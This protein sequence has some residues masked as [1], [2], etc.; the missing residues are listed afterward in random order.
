MGQ[1]CVVGS[2]ETEI[3]ISFEDKLDLAGVAGGESGVDIAGAGE[4]PNEE[5]GER[6]LDDTWRYI[7]VRP[8]VYFM[9]MLTLDSTSSQPI[10]PTP[11]CALRS[12]AWNMTRQ[13]RK[14]WRAWLMMCTRRR[15]WGRSRAQGFRRAPPRGI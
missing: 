13:S 6:M 7:A 5:V 9:F 3:R 15:A 4:Q 2:S 1:G 8:V 11:A 12:R 14:E 10:S